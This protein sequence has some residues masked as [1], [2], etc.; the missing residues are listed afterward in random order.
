MQPGKITKSKRMINKTEQKRFN[1]K[2]TSKTFLFFLCI[3]FTLLFSSSFAI[4]K[5]ITTLIVS[6]N[7]FYFWRT[8]IYVLIA[9]P[10]YLLRSEMSIIFFCVTFK[11][12]RL[13][14]L[15]SLLSYK[16][17]LTLIFTV[18]HFCWSSGSFQVTF[19]NIWVAVSMAITQIRCHLNEINLRAKWLGGWVGGWWSRALWAF[20]TLWPSIPCYQIPSQTVNF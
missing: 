20:I 4:Y 14:M 19:I 16:R 1:K 2:I 7:S 5:K 10:T 8:F 18:F 15:P 11:N 9:I 17:D 12:Y 6:I 13:L 3:W